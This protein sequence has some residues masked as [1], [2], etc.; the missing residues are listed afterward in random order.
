AILDVAA[1][2]K[3]PG[4][5][6][7]DEPHRDPT[8]GACILYTSGSTGVPKGTITTH[9]GIVRLVKNSNF[10]LLDEK[11]TLLQASSL[12]F[13]ASLFEIYGALLNG[14]ILALPDAGRL[15]IAA[16]TESLTKHQ[17]TTL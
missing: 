5:L 6:P 14:G 11:E 13:D 15:T 7:A 4:S 17:V 3:H 8:A 12:C 9:R 1:A 10:C 2:A 16:I